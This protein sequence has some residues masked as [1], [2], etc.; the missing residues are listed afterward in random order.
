MILTDREREKLHR[1]ILAYL[2]GKGF[3][4]AATALLNEGVTADDTAP[5]LLEKKWSSVV[6]LQQK[7]M[8]L[9]SEVTQMK[10]EMTY[11]GPGKK[12]TDTNAS[13]FDG[14]P[15]VPEKHTLT[16]HRETVTCAV[17]HP[18]YSI[19]ITSSEDGS[20][21]LWDYESGVFERALKGHTATVN[22]IAIEPNTGHL[23]ASASADLTVKLW[24]FE[25][26]ECIKTLNGH[27]HNV[28]CVEILPAGDFLVTSS[29]DRTMKLW[30]V[31][32]GFC[33]RTFRGHNEWVRRVT[34]NAQGSL[35]ATCSNDEAVMVWAI[36]NTSPIQTLTGHSNVVECVAFANSAAVKVLVPDSATEEEKVPGNKQMEI[37]ASGSRDKT[38]KLWEVWSG[39]C[40]T[41]LTGHDNWV[42]GVAFHPSGKFLYS[43]S[44]DKSIRVWEN[45]TG[46]CH[47]KLLD[48]HGHFV[49]CIAVNTRFPML[50]SGSVDKSVKVWE[51]R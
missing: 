20:I 2:R 23:L 37:V 4:S 41:T 5:D 13:K 33:V 28:S 42:R 48:A 39:N 47:K 38:I 22:Y 12:L 3:E 50:A 45:A 46:R 29:R 51:C 40:L 24:S 21:R 6:R 15:K 36:D 19:L 35:L 27:D 16:G 18:V 8:S 32:T 17:F 31:S 44:D 10:E 34:V 11:F 26:F 9:Q 14:L 43:C 1:A 7:V 25:T 49:T 30:E